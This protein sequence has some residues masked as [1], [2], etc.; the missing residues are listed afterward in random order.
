MKLYFLITALLGFSDLSHGQDISPLDVPSVI[1]NH[2]EAEFPN[3]K[4]VEWELGGELYE[5]EFEIGWNVDHEIWYNAQGEIVKHKED[6]ASSELPEAVKQTLKRDFKTYVIDDLQQIT[7]PEATV[8]EMELASLIKEEW[9]VLMDS[10][11]KVLRKV[12]D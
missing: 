4:D 10:S 8:Y 5:V 11:G 1:Q 3:A 2:F 7:T 12:A 6:I 9:D